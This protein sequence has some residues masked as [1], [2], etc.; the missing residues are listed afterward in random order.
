MVKFNKKNKYT[1]KIQFYF[2]FKILFFYSKI[3]KNKNYL[4]I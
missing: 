4:I 2:L 1:F 3:Y